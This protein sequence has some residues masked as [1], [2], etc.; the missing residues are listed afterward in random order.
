M[1]AHHRTEMNCCAVAL[2]HVFA[3]LCRP[4]V[5]VEQYSDQ[6]DVLHLHLHLHLLSPQTTN[7]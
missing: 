3:L 6:T 5:V 1:C 2:V 7:Q 4:D